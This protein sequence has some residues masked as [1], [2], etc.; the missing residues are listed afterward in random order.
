MNES[1]DRRR[2]ARGRWGVICATALLSAVTSAASAQEDSAAP[3]ASESWDVEELRDAAQILSFELTEG[4]WMSLDV[5]P[6][7]REI[8]FDLLGDLFTL[9][10]AG[11]DA[12][13]LRSGSAYELQPRY[14]PDGKWISFTS[15]RGGGDNI[16]VMGRDGTDARQVTKEDFRLLNNAVWTPDSRYLVARK[17]FTSRRSLG[18]GEMWMYPLDGGPGLQLTNKRNEQ[19]DS[20]EPWVAPDGRWLYWSEDVSPGGQYEYNRDPNSTIYAIRRLDLTRGDVETAIQLPGGSVR[21]TVSPDG[22][23][24]AFVR[25]MRG[26]SAL[27]LRDLASGADRVLVT[28]L[29]KDG[30]ETWSI[31]G[32]YPNFAWLPDASGLVYWSMGKLWRVATA[33]GAVVPIPFRANARHVVHDALRFPQAIGGDTMDVKVIRWPSVS[34]D[35]TTICFQALGEVFLRSQ[36]GGELRNIASGAAREFF[37]VFAPDSRRLAFVSWNDP[38]AG[39]VEILDRE[40]GV[41]TRL[42]DR[43]GH[44]AEPAFSPDG[45]WVVYRRGG[46]DRYR[47]HLHAQDPGI[48][49][50]PS[51]GSAPPRLVSRSGSEPRYT[52]T[53]ERI[54]LVD[55]EGEKTVLVSVDLLGGDR[56]VHVRMQY[57]GEL[58]PSPDESTLAFTQLFHVYV[59]PFP[60]TGRALEISPELTS[61]P[62]RKLS[63][64]GGEFLSWSADS[65]ALRFGL[66]PSF[67]E[68]EVAQ[69]LGAAQSAY[70]APA[71]KPLGFA[72][73]RSHTSDTIALTGARIIS[74]RGDEIIENGTVIVTGNRIT[75]VGPAATIAVPTGAT[76]IDVQGR[77]LLPGFVDVHAHSGSSSFGLIPVNK[78]AF[79]SMLAHGV[80]TTHDPSN[81]T[82]GI[83]AESE[84]QKTGRMVGPRVFST[85]TILYGA[86]GSFKAVIK[87]EADALQHLRRLKA[88]GAFSV[89]SYNQPRR[90][91]RQQV[92]AAARTLEMMV[93][94]EGGSMLHHNMTMILDGHTTIEHALPVAPLYEDCLRLFSSSR[95][96]YTPTLVVGY[97]GVFGEYYWYQHDPVWQRERLLSFVP[98]SVVDPRARRPTMIPD[99]EVNHIRLAE[100]AAAIFHRGGNVEIGAHGQMAGI[101]AHWEMWMFHQGGLTPHEVLQVGTLSG[102]RAIG[103]DHALGSVEAGKLADLIVLEA[104]PLANIRNTATVSLVMVDGRLYDAATL[105]EL[106]PH[107]RPLPP[108]P[109]LDTVPFEP[110][111]ACSCTGN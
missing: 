67:Y 39:H 64:D 50:V 40:S 94:P 72:V 11:G 90:E 87:S 8:V 5:S 57:D 48:Y 89:K 81:D 52:R 38:T 47:G 16:W 18:A 27:V 32:V 107:R 41:V 7:G 105:D 17:H 92:L 96:S 44:Y 36:S 29:S 42:T 25:R 28:G 10:I 19:Q 80:T 30:Q 109:P 74:M 53:G 104:D 37:P 79:H 9:P 12:R 59:L 22:K 65:R 91:Q 4:T 49:R 76:S 13:C 45:A 15:D 75:A 14:S 61:L 100:G 21:P 88:Y 2:T 73:E 23:T 1:I 20:G 26:A 83:F 85:G 35:G 24:L 34:P 103:L 95:T 6:D 70:Q 62:V 97:G 63:V 46:G 82:K 98:R 58:V 106:H 84:L 60:N 77:T 108:R 71:P 43:P 68:V 56:R 3:A 69:V 110:F 99:D 31:F 102:A 33:T 93:V 78:W 51:D 101:D 86:E 55:T 54:Y 111:H 66:G